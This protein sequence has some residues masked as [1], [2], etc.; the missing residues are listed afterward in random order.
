MEIMY[1]FYIHDPLME[2]IVCEIKEFVIKRKIC[3]AGILIYL[4]S[5]EKFGSAL[6]LNQTEKLAQLF[7]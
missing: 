1:L 4:A 3:V 5:F 6:F 7:F 2:E